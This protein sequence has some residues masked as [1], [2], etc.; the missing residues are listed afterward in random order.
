MEKLK[1]AR[2]LVSRRSV[3]EENFGGEK[4]LLTKNRINHHFHCRKKKECA[5]VRKAG[6]PSMME[7][8]FD[9]FEKAVQI[10]ILWLMDYFLW[11]T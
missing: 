9:V 10:C 3:I 1:P 6:D 5:I 4:K 2:S 11:G 8:T 7:S